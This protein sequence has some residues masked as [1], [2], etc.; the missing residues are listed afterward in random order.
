M[1]V[2]IQISLTNTGF[3]LNGYLYFATSGDGFYGLEKHGNALCKRIFYRINNLRGS[4]SAAGNPQP[5][6][7]GVQP[8][9]QKKAASGLSD[10]FKQCMFKQRLCGGAACGKPAAAP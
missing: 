6:Y 4:F 3:H 9:K 10:M 5:R 1:P 8:C 2:K 7:F